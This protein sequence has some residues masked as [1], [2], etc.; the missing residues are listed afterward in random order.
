MNVNEV[1]VLMLALQLCLFYGFNLEHPPPPTYKYIRPQ[2]REIS[3][4]DNFHQ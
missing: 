1:K 3:N 2:Y 4:Q